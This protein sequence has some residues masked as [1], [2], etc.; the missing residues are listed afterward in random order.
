[1]LGSR[2]SHV[3]MTVE[4]A[5]TSYASEIKRSDQDT[6]TKF[7]L[8]KIGGSPF[9]SS[10]IATCK[11][12][13]SRSGGGGV[14]DREQKSGGNNKNSG[15]NACVGSGGRWSLRGRGRLTSTRVEQAIDVVRP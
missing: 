1:M 3:C 6:P 10:L 15:R 8:V 14:T 13:R 7:D 9:F 4:I 2:L 5:K 12:S 11:Y